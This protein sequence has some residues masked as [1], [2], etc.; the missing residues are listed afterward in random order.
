MT[1]F[2][3]WIRGKMSRIWIYRMDVED[4]G[5][6]KCWYLWDVL[7]RLEDWNL[8]MGMAVFEECHAI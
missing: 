8:G 1:R 2:E 3:A 4:H 7:S 6:W 5:W